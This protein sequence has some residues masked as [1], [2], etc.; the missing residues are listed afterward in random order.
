MSLFSRISAASATRR[1]SPPESTRVSASRGGHRS[2]LSVDSTRR[3]RSHRS[4]ASISS[5]TASSSANTPSSPARVD[6]SSNRAS[7]S[8]LDATDAS[9][10]DPTVSPASAGSCARYPTFPPPACASPS[11]STSTPAMMRSSLRPVVFARSPPERPH[12]RRLPA[13]VPPHAADLR[14]LEERQVDP[15]QH[16]SVTH[17]LPHPGQRVRVP[18]LAPRTRRPPRTSPL[19]VLL[20]LPAHRHPRPFR[21]RPPRHPKRHRPRER[22]RHP[23]LHHT[24]HPHGHHRR[25]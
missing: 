16:H 8:R 7:V 3:S 25:A 19:L 21:S 2:A 13:P 10:A 4:R 15:V 9:T 1:R 23:V 18:L 11:N 22:H 24:H 20:L 12:S 17:L 6:S 5:W 14:P